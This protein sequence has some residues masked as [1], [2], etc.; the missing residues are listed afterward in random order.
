MEMPNETNKQL[1]RNEGDE[2]PVGKVPKISPP[3]VKNAVREG[4]CENFWE[5]MADVK[6][7]ISQ[8]YEMVY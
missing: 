2:V 8:Y 1:G 5:K 6:K 3:E 7:S 4:G